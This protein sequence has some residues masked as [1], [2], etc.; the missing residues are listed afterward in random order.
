MLDIPVSVVEG[1]TLAALKKGWNLEEKA[2]DELTKRPLGDVAESVCS[3]LK[4]QLLSGVFGV[5]QPLRKILSRNV[6]HARAID[7]LIG[8][9]DLDKSDVSIVHV[10]LLE[11]SYTTATYLT[12]DPAKYDELGWR[13][14]AF[15]TIHSI[16]NRVIGLGMPPTDEMN[17]WI[18]ENEKRL[19][20]FDPKGRLG[21]DLK[22]A[23]TLEQ[24]E[25][26][27]NWLVPASIKDIFEK[28]GRL[29]SYKK[30]GYD[31][32]SQSV[33]FSPMG[34]IYM[35]FETEHLTYAQFA[36]ESANYFVVKMFAVCLD[37]VRDKNE[38]R[39]AHALENLVQTYALVS[40]NPKRFA[41]LVSKQP[42]YAAF[43]KAV[44]AD[45]TD[46]QGLIEAALGKE[47]TS[48]LEIKFGQTS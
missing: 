5:E 36:Q 27:S 17:N 34:N 14:Q 33:H 4:K 47:A 13:W 7:A 23:K 28:A 41:D 44:M 24:W 21:G 37:L 29:D 8:A 1:A 40:T 19:I 26:C 25:K 43:M 48:K 15:P 11:E 12:L 30:K 9:K 10:R 39:K 16:R 18:K 22:S 6:E 2:I 32:G 38:I 20:W 35:S 31:M 46:I 3:I 42:A 45:S